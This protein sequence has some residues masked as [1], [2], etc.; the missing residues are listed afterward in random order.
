MTP[1]NKI[2][3]NRVTRPALENTKS[4]L[5]RTALANLDSIK[6]AD[7]V[8]PCGNQVVRLT[9]IQIIKQEEKRMGAVNTFTTGNYHCKPLIT[10]VIVIL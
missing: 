4:S 10:D 5:L 6:R 2:F 8:L 9:F 7:F 3:T 1:C